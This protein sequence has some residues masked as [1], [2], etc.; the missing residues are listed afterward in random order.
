M[1]RADA[2]RQRYLPGTNV[3]RTVARF[4]AARVADRAGGAR[5][6]AG[7]AVAAAGRRGERGST[8]ACGCER[9][10]ARRATAVLRPDADVPGAGTASLARP[11]RAAAGPAL[12]RARA[13]RSAPARP[14]G[15]RRMYERSLLVL[16]ALTDRR[17]GAVAAGARDGWAY[18][19]PRDASAAAIA[20]AAAGY[21]PEAERVTQF[22]LGLGLEDAA[23][24]H[25]DGS[26][27]PGRAAQG[28]AIGWVAAASQAAG[29]HRQRPTRGANPRRRRPRPLA[30]PRRLLGG[31]AGRLPRQRPR[32]PAPTCLSFPVI[33]GGKTQTPLVGRPRARGERPGVRPRLG[34]RLGG[35][36]L[37]PAPPLSRRSAQR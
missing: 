8:A 24:F 3:L 4:G 18:V 26:P 12:A 35:P 19:W 14:A 37:L 17:T 13:G 36:A 28:D 23:R 9:A 7:D 20:Y 2:V 31:R 1:W 27:V 22:L 25:G 21:R 15:R 33:Y 30:R 29:H 11:G 6:G 32:P 34:R 16:R 5:E 10:A